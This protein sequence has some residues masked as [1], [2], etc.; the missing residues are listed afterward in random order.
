MCE[1]FLHRGTIAE[2]R[3]EV[4]SRGAH[5][6]DDLRPLINSKPVISLLIRLDSEIMLRSPIQSREKNAVVDHFGEYTPDR[7]YVH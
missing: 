7:P 4:L 3:D 5:F 1:C 6:V 2:L